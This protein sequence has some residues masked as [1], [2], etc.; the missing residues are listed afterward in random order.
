MNQSASFERPDSSQEGL[1][2]WV[3][4]E[5]SGQEEE[6]YEPED[7]GGEAVVEEEEEVVLAVEE[8]D[9]EEAEAWKR[10]FRVSA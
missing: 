9:E 4:G 10:G 3:E 1:E 5:G 7:G 6:E 2:E 8:E